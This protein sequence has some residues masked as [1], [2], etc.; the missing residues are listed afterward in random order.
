ML[1]YLIMKYILYLFLVI[2]IGEYDGYDYQL[3]LLYSDES[4]H[5]TNSL[6]IVE[7]LGDGYSE[8]EKPI[9][10][11]TPETDQYLKKIMPAYDTRCAYFFC[12]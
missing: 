12:L 9:Y 11:T 4:Y 2:Y 10:K 7:H 8:S 1:H 3:R 6:N 5:N